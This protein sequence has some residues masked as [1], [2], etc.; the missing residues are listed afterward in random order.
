M[1][2]ITIKNDK[3]EEKEYIVYGERE[4]NLIL[5]INKPTN[6]PMPNYFE[7]ESIPSQY[8]TIKI[9]NLVP[10]IV[11]PDQLIIADKSLTLNINF[12]ASY[13]LELDEYE[14]LYDTYLKQME[15]NPTP[16]FQMQQTII[17][18]L[19]YTNSLTLTKKNKRA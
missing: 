17:N 11:I 1:F 19:K 10:I 15:N 16:E 12:L 8:P 13:P 2:A 7:L 18:D 5:N 4:L 3:N 6:L 9:T 14:T